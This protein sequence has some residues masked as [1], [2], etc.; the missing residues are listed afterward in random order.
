VIIN[1]G[2]AVPDGVIF[3]TK[4]SGVNRPIAGLYH[5]GTELAN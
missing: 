1:D 3:G 2:I 4:A 5:F